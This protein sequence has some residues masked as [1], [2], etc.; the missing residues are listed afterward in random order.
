[1]LGRMT[2]EDWAEWQAFDGIEPV[3]CQ[4][5]DW[6]NAMLVAAMVQSI[7][8]ASGVTAEV[9]IKRLMPFVFLNESIESDAEGAVPLAADDPAVVFDCLSSL[10]LKVEYGMLGKE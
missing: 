3:G 6:N 8:A 9:D 1:M 7:A 10:G 4:R 2:P 5:G